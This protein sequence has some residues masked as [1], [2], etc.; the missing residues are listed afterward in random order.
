MTHNEAMKILDDAIKIITGQK[1]EIERLQK[2]VDRL[3]ECVLYHDGHVVDAI[4]EFAERLKMK[5]HSYFLAD[6]I[7]IVEFDD[8]DYLVNEMIGG[9]ADV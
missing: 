6:L 7:W 2:E 5:A 8:I 9:E 4:M 1:A 3:S